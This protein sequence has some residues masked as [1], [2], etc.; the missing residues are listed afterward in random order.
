MVCFVPGLENV[1]NV[2]VSV[3]GSDI[4]IKVIDFVVDGVENFIK[5]FFLFVTRSESIANVMVLVSPDQ[6]TL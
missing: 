6:K 1:L 3:S 5:V 4:G 2:M